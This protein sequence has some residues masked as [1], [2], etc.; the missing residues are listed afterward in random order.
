MM[1]VLAHG[2]DFKKRIN[3]IFSKNIQG[4][5][6]NKEL[7]FTNLKSVSLGLCFLVGKISIEPF[8]SHKYIGEGRSILQIVV[9]LSKF[10]V[11]TQA[12][13]LS[14]GL[15][16]QV[17]LSDNSVISKHFKHPDTS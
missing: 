5:P 6:Y 2:T 16:L 7:V 1:T 8:S 13:G 14:L 9:G 17:M 10:T 15:F 12:S 4:Y 11:R 3:N